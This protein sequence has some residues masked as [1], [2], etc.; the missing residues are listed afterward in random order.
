MSSKAANF[1]STWS[2]LKWPALALLAVLVFNACFT[3]GFFHLQIR[4]GRIYG[5]L[6]DIVNRGAP[7]IL[8]SLGMTLVIATGGVDLSVGAVMAITGAIAA[9]LITRNVTSLLVIIAVPLI[10]SLIAGAWNGA[11]VGFVGVPPIVATLI[12]MV[13]GR[14]VAQLLTNGE[15]TFHHEA[16]SFIARGKFA[17]LPFPI[18]LVVVA[19]IVLLV[20]TQK[21]A[22]GLFIAATGDNELASRCAGLHT[23][24]VKLFVYVI[25]SFCAGIAGLI[26]AA[27]IQQADATHAG[28]WLELDAILATVIGG[29]ALQGG[30]F[31]LGGSLLGALL[32]QTV[33][34]TILTRGV[35]SQL[36]LV[37]KAL[38]VVSVCL[39]QSEK[40]RSAALRPLQRRFAPV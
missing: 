1:S 12:L 10:V 2:R 28:E 13:A 27:D 7:V 34:T 11:L 3:T 16:F 32:I 17:G 18:T 20:A 29:T 30:R 33:T 22:A 6:I 19:F 35:P 24:R 21:T 25:C 26:P 39:L 23:R 40:F 9:V 36:T 8:L 38:V 15:I 37:V 14:G 5:S 31:S 4:D